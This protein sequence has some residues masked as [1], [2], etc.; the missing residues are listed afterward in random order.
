MPF[1]LSS[2]DLRPIDLLSSLADEGED[3][4]RDVALEAPNGLELGMAL[5]DTLCDIALGA[6]VGAKPSDGDDV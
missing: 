5:G 2:G 6:G 1:C 3:L 4:S